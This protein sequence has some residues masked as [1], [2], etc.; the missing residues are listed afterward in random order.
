MLGIE[1]QNGLAHLCE[2]ECI[3]KKMADF[4]K[5]CLSWLLRPSSVSGTSGDK[6]TS[7]KPR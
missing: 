7:G 3:P 2:P 6:G 5:T 4:A 1:R